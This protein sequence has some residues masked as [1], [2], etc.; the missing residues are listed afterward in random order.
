MGNSI[1]KWRL[2]QQSKNEAST[3]ERSTRR[4]NLRKF[5]NWRT[6]IIKDKFW[7]DS[8]DYNLKVRV[9]N[10]MVWGTKESDL[11]VE[12]PNKSERRVCVI[13]NLLEST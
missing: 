4:K 5:K 3:S 10:C 2:N 6:N 9:Y 13:D 8:L 7:W 12:F 11:K 1:N